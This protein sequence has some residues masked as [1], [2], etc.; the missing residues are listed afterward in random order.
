[1]FLGQ[2]NFPNPEA[3]SSFMDQIT[4]GL[5]FVAGQLDQMTGFLA[6]NV[7]PMPFFS[8]ANDVNSAK[9]AIAHQE[10]LCIRW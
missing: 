2:Q 9:F 6:Q 10:Y 1:M 4:K 5:P 8:L 3:L 7:R